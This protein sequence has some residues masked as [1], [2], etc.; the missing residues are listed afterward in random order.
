MR[1]ERIG[2]AT[3]YTGDVLSVLAGRPMLAFAG[4]IACS[5]P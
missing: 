4:G 2:D 5:Q 3:L 1:I